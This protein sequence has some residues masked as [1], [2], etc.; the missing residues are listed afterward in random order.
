MIKGH[1]LVPPLAVEEEVE[2]LPLLP[3]LPLRN[4]NQAVFTVVHSKRYEY[5]VRTS[6]SILPSFCSSVSSSSAGAWKAEHP[7]TAQHS[8]T[9][10]A[11][12]KYSS[13]YQLPSQL[14]AISDLVGK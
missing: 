13:S 14:M 9:Y 12:S 7:S 11:S 3:V 2:Q 10:P 1:L 4:A 5:L 8:P 6:S